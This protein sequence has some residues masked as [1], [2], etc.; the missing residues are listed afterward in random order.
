MLAHDLFSFFRYQTCVFSSF[1]SFVHSWLRSRNFIRPIHLAYEIAVN[2]DKRL[3]QCAALHVPCHGTHT[4]TC[5]VAI[6]WIVR[7]ST[8]CI[9]LICITSPCSDIF[10]CATHNTR[11]RYTRI[12][13][14]AY[15][16]DADI[17][18]RRM[19]RKTEVAAAAAAA[20]AAAAPTTTTNAKRIS[21]RTKQRTNYK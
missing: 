12:V 5:S 14:N 3:W 20:E 9:W 17:S 11:F 7:A 4:H 16:A 2:C 21:E 10:N 18:K 15:R 6:T 8:A 13:C 19:K 1:V